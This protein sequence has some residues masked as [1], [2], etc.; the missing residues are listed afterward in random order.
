MPDFV[1]IAEAYSCAGV[2]VER[3][4]ELPDA[5]LAAQKAD[6]PFVID[7]VIDQ[8]EDMLP[9]MPP[10]KSAKDIILGPRC[11]WKGGATVESPV[12]ARP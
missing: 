6:T 11:I 10:G 1:K 2:H 8:K 12:P 7:A 5:I 9:I 3:A 4:S